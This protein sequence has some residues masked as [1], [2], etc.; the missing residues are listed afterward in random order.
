[1]D[2]AERPAEAGLVRDDPQ[3]VRVALQTADELAALLRVPV[4]TVVIT[5][6]YRGEGPPFLRI[7]Q[8]IRYDPRGVPDGG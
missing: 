6:R 1:M 7:D 3:Q 2:D 5:W 8:Y 4:E